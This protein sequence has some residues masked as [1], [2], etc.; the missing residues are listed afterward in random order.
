M[1]MRTICSAIVLGLVIGAATGVGQNV[2]VNPGFESGTLSPWYE[3][4]TGG[5][6]SW[7]VTTA[8][9]HSGSNAATCVG[10]NR[11]RQDF[12][13]TPTDQITEVSF[14]ILQ[15][16]TGGSGYAGWFRYSDNFEEQVG[17][18]FPPTGLPEWTK[19]D[20]TAFLQPGRELV[21]FGIWGYVNG[22]P[23]EDRTYIDDVLIATGSSRGDM[24][25]DGHVDFNDINPFVLA[26]SNPAGYAQQ[27]PNCNIMNG[28][29]NGDGRVE[30]GDINPFVALLSGV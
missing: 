21:A 10:N 1:S 19:I 30:F 26:L 3:D 27:Y 5:P 24:N 6:E 23:Q 8:Q 11:I 14:W 18:T 13:A 22:S 15:P 20:M 25:C 16:D 29:C 12:A 7:H 4:F 28:D 9:S 2:L 17:T